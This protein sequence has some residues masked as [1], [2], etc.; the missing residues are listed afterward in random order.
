MVLPTQIDRGDDDRAKVTEILTALTDP[1]GFGRA[2]AAPGSLQVS[3][4]ARPTHA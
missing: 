3:A 2:K 4:Q 1:F